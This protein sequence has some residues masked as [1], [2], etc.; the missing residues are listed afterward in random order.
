MLE[1]DRLARETIQSA[2]R[3]SVETRLDR[4]ESA[5]RLIASATSSRYLDNMTRRDVDAIL[6]GGDTRTEDTQ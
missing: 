6:A 3:D 5:L 1:R 2:K 4:I